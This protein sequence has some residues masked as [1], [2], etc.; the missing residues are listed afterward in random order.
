MLTP[1]DTIVA[2]MRALAK[3][4]PS[5]RVL[6]MGRSHQ[7]REMIAVAVGKPANLRKLDDIAAA[8]AALADPRVTD[9]ERAEEL[10]KKTPLLYMTAGLH[11]PETGPPEMVMELAYRLAVSKQPHIRE[12]R[13]DVVVLISPVLEMD[14][15]A[16]MVDWWRRHLQD[17]TE[18]E[19]SPPRMAPFWG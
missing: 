15:R 8:N 4:S 3:A 18:L 10:V 19:D 13:D 12:I 14:G 7:G 5:V 17:V 11:S 16:R 2:Y 9:R 1:P 6:E